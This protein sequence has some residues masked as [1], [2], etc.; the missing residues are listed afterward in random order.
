MIT[1]S[2][3]GKVLEKVVV[4]FSQFTFIFS[5]SFVL[6]SENPVFYSVDVSI[7]T[8]LKEAGNLLAPWK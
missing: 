6:S 8:L 5:Y 3:L 2:T 4:P 7:F 1:G